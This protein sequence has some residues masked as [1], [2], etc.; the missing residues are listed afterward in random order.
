VTKSYLTHLNISQ[1]CSKLC[2]FEFSTSNFG[3]T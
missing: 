2:S 3:W 1:H